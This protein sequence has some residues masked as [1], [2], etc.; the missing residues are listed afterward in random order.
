MM[1]DEMV[2][3]AV[4]AGAREARAV[5][6]WPTGNVLLRVRGVGKDQCEA[7]RKFMEQHAPQGYGWE[8][9]PD[10]DTPPPPA[11]WH[12]ERKCCSR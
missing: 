3:L 10:Y 1:R 2:G 5:V 9:V 7:I 4:F 8:V 11:F 12:R 6:L